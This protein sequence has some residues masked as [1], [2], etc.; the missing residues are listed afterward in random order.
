MHVQIN[1]AIGYG[2]VDGY[3]I[4]D[5][6]EFGRHIHFNDCVAIGGGTAVSGYQL[7]AQDIQLNN[8]RASR[9][10]LRGAVMVGTSSNCMVIGG[11]YAYS[12]SQGISLNGSYH[13]VEG[14]RIHHNGGAGISYNSTSCIDPKIH[15]CDIYE[16]ASYGIQDGGAAGAIR[17]VVQ[18]CNIPRSAAQT[19]AILSPSATAIIEGCIF[20]GY[21]GSSHGMTGIQAG[22]K[23]ANILTDGGIVGNM[24]LALGNPSQASPVYDT[25]VYRGGFDT[26]RT[27]STILATDGKITFGSGA[28]APLIW[29]GTGTPEGVVTAPTGSV[30]LRT[31]GG[32]GSSY[33]V[34]ESGTGNTGWV[35]K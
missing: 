30:F 26:I 32:A 21:G 28:T 4:F 29:S 25:L 27:D 6:H 8:C 3:S 9:C 31:D 23:V 15:S 14:V 19:S 35:A 13:R 5:T 10:G 33:Y 16:N 24:A 11:E 7:R 1:G 17:P 20:T 2:G 12:G 22:A 34:K 18:G